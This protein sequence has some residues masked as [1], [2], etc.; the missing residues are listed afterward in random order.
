MMSLLDQEK[1]F[2]SVV[3]VLRSVD[4]CRSLSR[5]QEEIQQLEAVVRL[6]RERDEQIRQ[7]DAKNNA[8]HSPIERRSGEPY[9]LKV[10][11][12]ISPEPKQSASSAPSD[13]PKGLLSPKFGR[14]M[15]AESMDTSADR[16]RREM[17]A[18]N[19]EE[20]ER[21][22]Q[23]EKKNLEERERIRQEEEKHRLA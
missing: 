23:A 4:W 6:L 21:V 15:T 3:D 7:Q 13:L 22:K 5:P 11:E 19:R 18:R 8:S 14:M 17:E 1:P 2:C 16:F 10:S 20:A 12:P 9:E